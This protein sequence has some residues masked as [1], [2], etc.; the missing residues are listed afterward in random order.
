IYLDL[1]T[2]MNQMALESLSNDL[3]RHLFE[4][5]DPANILRAFS[6]LNTRFNSLLYADIQSYCVDLR[7]MQVNES[8]CWC[9]EY[10]KKILTFSAQH[11]LL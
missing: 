2:A 8:D 3:L 11:T 9:L 6:G 10:Q 5:F 4:L 1:K 7:L